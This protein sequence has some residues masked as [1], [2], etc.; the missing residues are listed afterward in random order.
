MDRSHPSELLIRHRLRALEKNLPGARKGNVQAVHQARVASR[1]LREAL[2]VVSTGS[3][4]RRLERQM[5]KITRALGPVRDL[6]VAL[7]MLDDIERTGG[8]SRAALMR[9]RQAVSRERQLLQA[10]LEERIERSHPEKLRKRALAAARRDSNGE[11][12]ARKG[13]PQLVHAARRMARRAARLRAAIENAS[14]MYLPERLHEV[15]IAVKKLRYS[16]E[17]VREL[18]GSRATARIRVLKRTQELLGR[19][20]DLEVLIARTRAV[21]GAENAPSLKL[22]A[23]LDRLVRRFENECRQLHAIYTSSRPSLLSVC[24]H[25]VSAAASNLD[26]DAAA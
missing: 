6:D 12:S 25:A 17:L 11:G 7:Q 18:T 26:A 13:G 5:R 22:S 4:G 10:G 14:G 15:R 2:P 23:E 19:V 24:D 21:Q 1:R 9:L 20:R 8:A 3:R 16:M